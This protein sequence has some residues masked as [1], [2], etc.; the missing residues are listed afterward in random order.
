M[1]LT[2]DKRK[3]LAAAARRG[4]RALAKI[5]AETGETAIVGVAEA[6]EFL[7]VGKP[8]IWRLIEQGQMPASIA[9]LRSGQVWI[10][11]ELRPLRERLA[12]RRAAA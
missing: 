12:E 11:E 8:K 1:A 5:E 2:A 4:R 6:A 9:S 7:E 3:E 10:R